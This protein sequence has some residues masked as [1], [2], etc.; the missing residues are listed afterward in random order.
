M[1]C[2]GRPLHNLSLQLPSPISSFFLFFL[3]APFFVCLFFPIYFFLYFFPFPCF[4]LFLS[5]FS[6]FPHH[7]RLRLSLDLSRSSSLSRSPSAEVK[8]LLLLL[9]FSPTPA[10]PFPLARLPYCRRRPRLHYSC[11]LCALSPLARARRRWAR[12]RGRAGG[13]GPSRR[14]DR[15]LRLPPSL[16]PARRSGGRPEGSAAAGAEAAAAVRAR[17]GSGGVGAGPRGEDG[18][19]E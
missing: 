3:C 13:V 2:L 16:S 6:S 7:R 5:L 8:L 15:A 17:R 9:P 1:L 19:D 11:L 4:L 12:G 18:E 14:R 10:P